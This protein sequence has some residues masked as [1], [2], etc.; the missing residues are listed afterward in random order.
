MSV[1][2]HDCPRCGAK[3]MTFDVNAQ[4]WRQRT[5][6]WKN[7]YEIFCVCRQCHASTT[8]VVSDR[9]IG[10]SRDFSKAGALVQF[11]HGLNDHFIVERHVS[12]RD[13]GTRKPPEHLA[14]PLNDA[15]TEGTACL[16]TG[17]P[18]AAGT[19]FR[20]CVDLVTRPML[21]DPADVTKKQPNDK[22]RRDLGLR[23]PWL[24]DN[25]Y[26]PDA[27]RDLAKAIRE[28]G[29]DGAHQGTLS[30]EDAEDIADFTAA[31][32]ERLITEP[33][34][35]KEAEAR[36]QERRAKPKQ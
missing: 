26:L 4:L 9:E 33:A 12:L 20:L 16:A 27:F 23:I 35:L 22:Q 29:N 10:S 14:K 17:C 1:L 6:D 11:G 25:G 5:F 8:F 28:D 30:A 18:N 3:R 31:L 32:L 7:Y 36:R 24:I 13:F 2:V 19:M 21:P 15:F 34:R